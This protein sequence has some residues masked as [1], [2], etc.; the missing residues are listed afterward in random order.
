[1]NP[2]LILGVSP[3]ANDSEIR[4]AYLERVRQFPPEQAPERF[5]AV[6]HAYESI[7][8][9]P[10]RLNYL[11]FDRQADAESPFN[12]LKKFCAIAPLPKPLEFEALKNYLRS[13]TTK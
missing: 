10:S 13:C 3:E 11:L 12:A 6:S 7:R 4:R 8:D 1:M 2:Y 5:Q 9:E